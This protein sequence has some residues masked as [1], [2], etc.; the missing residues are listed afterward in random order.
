MSSHNRLFS[1]P[2]AFGGLEHTFSQMI[3]LCILQGSMVTFSG[4]VGKGITVCFLQ[5]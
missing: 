1:E 5:S 3:K 4:V 2:P